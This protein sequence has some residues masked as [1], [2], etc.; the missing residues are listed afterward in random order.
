[1]YNNFKAHIA[2]AIAALFSLDAMS[3][4][5][6]PPA[7]MPSGSGAGASRNERLQ[8]QQESR[9]EMLD[10][11]EKMSPKER[12]QFR[13]KIKDHWKNMTP[14][15]QEASRQEMRK[16]FKNMSPEERLQLQRDMG[17]TSDLLPPIERLPGGTSVP[18]ASR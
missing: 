1:M 17:K 16:H 14:E 10:H 13:K 2:A 6:P 11:W 3:A 12:E 7:N 15:E 18:K 8:S 9:K 4:D 5:I